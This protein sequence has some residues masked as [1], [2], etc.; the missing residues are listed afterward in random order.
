MCQY[1]DTRNHALLRIYYQTGSSKRTFASSKK[2]VVDSKLKPTQVAGLGE[3]AYSTT[4]R[5][6][7]KEFNTIVF[8]HEGTQTSISAPAPLAKVKLLAHQ[9]IATL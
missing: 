9:V 2:A 7:D 4:T 6:A 8:L 3:M 5:S 1:T